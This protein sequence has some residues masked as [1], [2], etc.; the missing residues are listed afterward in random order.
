MT[1]FKTAIL[2]L[3][4]LP[5]LMLWG[6]DELPGNCPDGDCTGVCDGGTCA[7]DDDTGADDDDTGGFETVTLHIQSPTVATRPDYMEGAP[8]DLD[9]R[10]EF[11]VEGQ[12]THENASECVYEVDE[13]VTDLR[14][15]LDGEG[16]RCA[17]N[18][19]TV[20]SED[21][22]AELDVLWDSPY[23]CATDPDGEYG[24]YD[25]YTTLNDDGQV[26]IRIGIYMPAP[27]V[28]NEF[29]AEDGDQLMEG[30]VS[31]D[32]SEIYFR[33]ITPAGNET[34]RTVY[35]ND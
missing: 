24:T 27:I 34:E 31:W 13:P 1:R 20:S 26:E 4:L 12:L 2:S 10:G 8:E 17:P 18:F 25:V 21:N 33:T 14:V 3:C 30:T 29:Y 6:C 7:D 32:L 19:A 5:L 9:W 11:R 15:T 35:R 28:G 22:G 23:T 16:F